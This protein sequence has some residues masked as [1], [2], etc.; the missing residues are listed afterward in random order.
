MPNIIHRIGIRAPAAQVYAALATIDGLAGWWTR[1]TTGVS[2]VGEVIRFGF[3]NPSGAEIG[4]FE[5][6]VLALGPSDLVRWRVRGGPPEW[7]GTT[8]SF[9]LKEQNGMTLVM[10]AHREWREEVEFMAHCSMKWALFLV[11]LRDLVER[12]AGQP[13]PDDVKIDD[14]N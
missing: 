12:G 11:S 10:F 1:D 2:Q 3:R 9:Q 14:W 4:H 7:V 8:I 5:M 13:A 6:E